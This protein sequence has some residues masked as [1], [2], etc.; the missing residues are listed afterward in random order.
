[1]HCFALNPFLPV[2][3]HLGSTAGRQLLNTFSASEGSVLNAVLFDSY[4]KPLG[5]FEVG[6]QQCADDTL[7]ST[8][9]YYLTPRE[10]SIP[11]IIAY[12]R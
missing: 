8:I 10:Q 2:G 6:C 5:E 4:K 7:S 11:L 12:F 1:M 9:P 3:T